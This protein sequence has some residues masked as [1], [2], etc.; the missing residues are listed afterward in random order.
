MSHSKT[1]MPSKTRAKHNNASATDD[2]QLTATDATEHSQSSIASIS[3]PHATFH[4][5]HNAYNPMQSQTNPSTNMSTNS[6]SIA[7]SNANSITNPSTTANANSI[8][9][10]NAS[11]NPSTNTI[12]ESSPNQQQQQQQMQQQQLM[13][14]STRSIMQSNQQSSQM[15]YQMQLPMQMSMQMPMQIPMQMQMQMPHA[16]HTQ[17]YLALAQ[18]I[19]NQQ[20]MH[21]S[22]QKLSLAQGS[23]QTQQINHNQTQASP[24]SPSHSNMQTQSQ[25]QAIK[26]MQMQMQLQN[27]INEQQQNQQQQQQQQ[28]IGT[29]SNGNAQY[30]SFTSA[31][32]SS[33]WQMP[34]YAPSTDISQHNYALST[35]SFQQPPQYQPTNAQN[36]TSLGITQSDSDGSD[37]EHDE[38]RANEGDQYDHVTY[39]QESIRAVQGDL[40]SLDYGALLAQTRGLTSKTQAQ[41]PMALSMQ[42]PTHF[43]Q[44]SQPSLAEVQHGRY[45]LEFIFEMQPPAEV[46]TRTPR[47]VRNFSLVG[48]V[49]GRNS[50]SDT[51][52]LVRVD[53]F[54]APMDPS[55]QPI[56]VPSGDRILGGTT[57]VNVQPNGMVV[58]NNL[59][60]SEASTKHNEREFVLGVTV[61]GGNPYTP[62]LRKFSRPFYSYSHKKVLERR[63]NLKLRTISTPYGPTEGHTQ[64]HIIGSPFISGPSFGIV[65]S[66]PYGSVRAQNVELYSDCVAFF[67]LPECPGGPHPDGVEIMASVRVTNDGRNYSDGVP[68][69]YINNNNSS[70][71]G[72][73]DVGTS[74]PTL[75]SK[76]PRSSKR[77]ADASLEKGNTHP[78]KR[79]QR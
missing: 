66:T 36:A 26:Q 50:Y 72:A 19:L 52:F 79:E 34:S 15:P 1:N 53:L 55:E 14:S 32:G 35:Q 21:P 30:P 25:P 60:M 31:L 43:Q 44:Q 46:R 47:E 45:H 76:Q 69:T 18:A 64:L 33:Q 8:A 9:N 22:T 48:T 70:T 78:S 16:T 39:T 51:Q 71:K 59:N 68:F 40:R 74:Q 75:D 37:S 77:R 17:E 56:L 54:Y 20:I 57:C 49:V 63:R 7:N 3:F 38:Q 12:V 24:K 11:T 2:T 42:I 62:V 29:Q 58:F 10:A 27:F 6:N 41:I 67:E 5:S 4:P 13:Q 61:L 65:F 73:P 23:T 28:L